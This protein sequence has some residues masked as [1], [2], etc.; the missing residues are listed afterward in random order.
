[1]KTRIHTPRRQR[2]PRCAR[3][4]ALRALVAAALVAECM[5]ACQIGKII[6]ICDGSH[7]R[8]HHHLHPQKLLMLRPKASWVCGWMA[9]RLVGAVVPRSVHANLNMG[10]FLRA[11]LCSTTPIPAYKIDFRAQKSSKFS[12]GL[13]HRTPGKLPL[14]GR[15]CLSGFGPVSTQSTVHATQQIAVCTL[16]DKEQPQKASV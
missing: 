12:R 13:R 11:V 6:V 4:G 9:R 1:M 10:L 8:N 16:H 3:G 15:T 14:L 2:K 7:A 5:H